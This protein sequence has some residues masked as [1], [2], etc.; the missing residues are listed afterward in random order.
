MLT[1]VFKYACSANSMLG[2]RV[3]SELKVP[4]VRVSKDTLN[5]RDPRIAEQLHALPVT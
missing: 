2:G 4:H 5:V 1:A 3:H